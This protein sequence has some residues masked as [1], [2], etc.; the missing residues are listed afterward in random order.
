[1]QEKLKP[2]QITTEK[3]GT[4]LE[5]VF[6]QLENVLTTYLQTGDGS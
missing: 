4:D 5:E 1:M 6:C 2:T 3:H